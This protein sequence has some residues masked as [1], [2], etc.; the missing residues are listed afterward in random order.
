V[1][2]DSCRMHKDRHE[3]PYKCRVEGCFFYGKGFTSPTERDDHDA[4]CHANEFWCPVE[5]CKRKKP[6]TRQEKVSNHL[7]RMHGLLVGDDGTLSVCAGTYSFLWVRTFL[8]L[9]GERYFADKL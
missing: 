1:V 8:S 9:A 7:K 5:G 6:F 2:A 3:R 4:E